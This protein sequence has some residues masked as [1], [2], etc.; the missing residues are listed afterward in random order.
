MKRY[1]KGFERCPKIFM[2]CNQHWLKFKRIVGKSNLSKYNIC[3][4]FW[5]LKS[6][7]QNTHEIKYYKNITLIKKTCLTADRTFGRFKKKIYNLT[8][9]M[10][11]KCGLC[12]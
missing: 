6:E 3:K 7:S 2:I 12:H 8:S 1:F 4:W 9:K 11:R 10:L 5:R